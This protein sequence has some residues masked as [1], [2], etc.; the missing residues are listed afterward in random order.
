MAL[1]F[2][3]FVYQWQNAGV[4]DILLPFLLVFTL[5]YAVLDKVKILGDKKN[6]NAIVSLVLAFFFLQNQFLIASVQ[7]LLPNV[8]FAVIIGLMFLLVVGVLLGDNMSGYYQKVSLK[9]AVGV[10]IFVLIWAIFSRPGFDFTNFQDIL[11]GFLGPD[12]SGL[13]VFILII[14]AAFFVVR[15]GGDKTKEEKK[16]G[17]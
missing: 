1:D 3:S 4:Y 10:A 5:T 14:T 15:G 13:L 11:Y 12:A 17:G 9:V 8:S 6:L 16:T 7:S 2:Y